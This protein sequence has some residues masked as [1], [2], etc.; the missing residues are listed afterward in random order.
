MAKPVSCSHETRW[1]L[2]NH[3]VRIVNVN[4]NV[5]TNKLK[6]SMRCNKVAFASNSM[7]VDS[8][9]APSIKC[10]NRS[11]QQPKIDD[12]E[13]NHIDCLVLVWNGVIVF[14]SDTDE[15]D[16]KLL[17]QKFRFSAILVSKRFVSLITCNY[18]ILYFFYIFWWF[19]HFVE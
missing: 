3:I 2:N 11:E 19:K 14:A 17:S 6:L 9:F 18:N 12:F 16:V 13:L 1:C 7:S 10:D 4:R 8:Q 5:Y 15:T